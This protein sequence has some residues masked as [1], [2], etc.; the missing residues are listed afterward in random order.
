MA[1]LAAQQVTLAGTAVT[2]SSAAGGGDRVPVGPTNWVRV[3]NGSGSSVNVTVDSIKPCDQGFDHN[4]VVAVAAGA[5]KD[6]G[7][8]TP[9]RFQDT[10][11]LA[12]VNYSL[13]TSVTVAAVLV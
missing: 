12:G 7:P 6:I 10:D 4:L 1:V 5:T 11:G 9:G 2:M 13:A 8:L 3:T